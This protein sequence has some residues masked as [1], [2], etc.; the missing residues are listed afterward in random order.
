MS[1][2]ERQVS[3]VNKVSAENL[4]EEFERRQS[5]VKACIKLCLPIL[6]QT[7][8]CQTL[9]RLSPDSIGK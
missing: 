9:S 4:D 7:F 8:L 6:M 3:L 1:L 5:N 2:M